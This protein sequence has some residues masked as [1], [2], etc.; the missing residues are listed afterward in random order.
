MHFTC[1]INRHIKHQWHVRTGSVLKSTETLLLMIHYVPSLHQRT[2]L[3]GDQSV[4]TTATKSAKNFG[5]YS[6]WSCKLKTWN[7]VHICIS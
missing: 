7:L 3:C 2:E 5:V 4:N 6:F 1:A